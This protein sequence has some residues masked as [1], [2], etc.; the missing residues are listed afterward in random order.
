MAVLPE[1]PSEDAPQSDILVILQISL[2]LR[3]SS[4][5]VKSLLNLIF[6]VGKETK[7]IIIL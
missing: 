2:K 7:E 6:T 4:L 3:G 5:R 1:T